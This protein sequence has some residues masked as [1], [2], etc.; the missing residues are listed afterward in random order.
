MTTNAHHLKFEQGDIIKADLNPVEGHEQ[1]GYRPLLVISNADFNRLTRLVKVVPI[2]T[3]E[4]NFPLNVKLDANLPVHGQILTEHERTI[5]PVARDAFWVT[6]CPDDVL[7]TVLTMVAE[8][9]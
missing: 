5:D 3:G 1:A 6:K 7:K 9:Y 4:D 8:T 2:T